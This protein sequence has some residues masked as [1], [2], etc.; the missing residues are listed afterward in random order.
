MN[1]LLLSPPRPRVEQFFSG[2]QD[3]LKRIE[4][5]L[6]PGDLQWAWM[7][8]A[9]SFGYRH[10]LP[11]EITRN[12]KGKIINVHISYLPWNRG[13]D[14]NLWSFLGNTPKGVSV[15]LIDEGM[16]TGPILAQQPVAMLPDDTLATSFQ[17]L[18]RAGEALLISLWNDYVDGRIEPR[19]QT[20]EG[21]THRSRD[22]EPWLPRLTH[23]WETPVRSLEGAALSGQ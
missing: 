20:G 10:L 23:G 16:D 12:F 9:V 4:E 15:H 1:L 8:Y 6:P 13:A 21:T 2:R 7:D 18:E 14:P 17:R 22:K 5:Q 3:C 11:E 19:A